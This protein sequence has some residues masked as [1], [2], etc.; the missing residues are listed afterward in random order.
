MPVTLNKF[1][2]A[3]LPLAILLATHSASSMAADNS[4]NKV[5]KE[6]NQ[7]DVEMIVVRGQATTGLDRLIDQEQLEKIQA[8]NL[9]D[10]FRLDTSINV[11]GSVSSSQKIYLRNVGEDML[12]ISIDGAEIAEAVFHHTGRIT[13]EPEI[14]KQVEVEAGAGSAAVG[15]GALGGAVRM[16][17]KSPID[18]LKKDQNLGGILKAS[19]LANGSGNKYSLT[20]YAADEDRKYSAMVNLVSSDSG[21]LED[22]D[23][24]EIVG[25]G[26]EKTLGYLKGV[27]YLT[28][29]QYLSISYENLEEE[30]NILYKPELI[31]SAKNT[32][33]PTEGTRESIILNYGY[34][35]LTSDLVDFRI[36]AYQSDQ[37]QTRY[38]GEDPVFGEVKS[39]GLNI[40]NKSLFTSEL[41][42]VYL[43][44]GLNYRADESA[45][46]ETPTHEEG[47]VLGVFAQSVINFDDVLTISTGARFDDY[48]LT[49]WT[50][51]NITDSGISPNISASYSLT[52]SLGL[53]A[54][55]ASAI[56]GPKVKDSYKVGYY[57]NDPDLKAETAT[58]LEFGVD[59]QGENFEVG[60]GRYQSKI[61][62]PIGNM[63]PWGKLAENL[64]HDLETQGYY[65]QFDLN[66][67][68][69]YAHIDLNHATSEFNGD[70]ATR[71]FHSSTATSMGDNYLV[72]L[73]Y[74]FNEQLTLGW[75][76]QYVESMDPFE[77]LV[78][79]GGAYEETL[80]ASKQGYSLHDL[81]ASWSPTEAIKINLAVKNLFDKTYLSQGSVEDLRHNPGYEIISG[82]NSAGRDV[83]L[84]LSYQF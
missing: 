7:D 19:H 1:K 12:Y 79:E 32:L 9:E 75:V 13:V 37:Q 52:D 56:R 4:S 61:K 20:A 6:I 76:S 24:N 17:T 16:T 71:Y 3:S 22:G 64:D 53:S 39:Q 54:G 18:L 44:Y 38:Y 8:N 51:L 80:T 47:K 2:F 34:D 30:G 31:P 70:T 58:N 49:D 83:R 21:N 5:K 73:S 45:L 46:A 42:N 66:I 59:Y 78:D 57:T 72:D 68:K 60:V 81:Y 29:S 35:N 36:T 14:L 28:D 33:S 48:E 63:A 15:P 67:N 10:I 84:T 74:V 65:L 26:S 55:F 69:F 62:D 50:G 77:I 27:A 43:V 25:S 41:A 23:G 40:Q 11:G 82:Q